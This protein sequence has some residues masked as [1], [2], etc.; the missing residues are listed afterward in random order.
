MMDRH[1]TAKITV[2]RRKAPKSLGYSW[3]TAISKL[4]YSQM[5]EA[6]L[7]PEKIQPTE[8]QVGAVSEVLG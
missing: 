2:K 6:E 4:E 8:M 5:M 1:N 3:K 7:I